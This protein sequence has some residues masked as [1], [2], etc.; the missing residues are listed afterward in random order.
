R[1]NGEQ[2]KERSNLVQHGGIDCCLQDQQEDTEQRLRGAKQQVFSIDTIV[3]NIASFLTGRKQTSPSPCAVSHEES[4]QGH[5]MT[6]AT[7]NEVARSDFAV[8]HGVPRCNIEDSHGKSVGLCLT[9]RAHRKVIKIL[10]RHTVDEN[11]VFLDVGCSVSPSIY[12]AALLGFK[13]VLGL[14]QDKNLMRSA[15]QNHRNLIKLP[16]LKDLAARIAHIHFQVSMDSLRAPTDFLRSLSV[17][18]DFLR[19]LL[20]SSIAYIKKDANDISSLQG[21]THLFCFILIELE[22]NPLGHKLIDAIRQS[23]T[24]RYLALGSKQVATQLEEKHGFHRMHP[25]SIRAPLRG[26]N[27]K[28]TIYFLERPAPQDIPVRNIVPDQDIQAAL[29][30]IHQGAQATLRRTNAIYELC[31]PNPDLETRSGRSYRK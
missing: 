24:L 25:E 20:V 18:T 27:E 14:E 30:D 3:N 11:S 10:S 2:Q 6:M 23:T 16:F 21:I 17:A 12:F 28:H 15:T 4:V 9:D 7:K 22:T 31:K 8:S 29:E 5:I 26:G 1:V 19:N 13:K